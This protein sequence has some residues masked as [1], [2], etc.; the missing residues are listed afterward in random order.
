MSNLIKKEETIS[1]PEQIQELMRQL[2]E[3][4]EKKE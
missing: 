3:Y 1:L 4:I 2:S